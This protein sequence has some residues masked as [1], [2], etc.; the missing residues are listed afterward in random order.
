MVAY[1]INPYGGANSAVTSASL[2]L[3]Q[4]TWGK[5]HVAATPPYGVRTGRDGSNAPTYLLIV[6]GRT[7]P[8]SRCVP[9]WRWWRAPA[10]DATGPGQ[11]LRVQ[12]AAGQFLQVVQRDVPTATSGGGLS[13]TLVS[14]SKPV[15]L[16]GGTACF[17]MDAATQACD[18]GHQQ[19]PAFSA[20]GRE[21]VAV[22][23]RSR[24]R[25]RPEAVPWQIVGAVDGTVLTYEP[26]GSRPLRQVSGARAHRP[27]RRRV[28]DLLDRRSLRGAQPGR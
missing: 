2:L 5:D 11:V 15:A 14:S 27:V 7:T 12:L 26:P 17:N 24:V 1:D 16:I 6:A 21:Y 23:H 4:E 8:R 13:G 28:G 3:P 19:I 18:S 9:P 25:A 10:L 22:P 20:W